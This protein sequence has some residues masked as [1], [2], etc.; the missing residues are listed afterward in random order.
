MGQIDIERSIR[1]RKL[2]FND[3]LTDY[4]SSWIDRAFIFL[5][6]ISTIYFSLKDLWHGFV[7]DNLP[8]VRIIVSLLFVSLASWIIYA[9]F[10]VD[11][12]TVI[13]GKEK[14]RN[15]ELMNAILAKM[16]S[17]MQFFNINDDLMIGIRPGRRRNS[18]EEIKVIYKDSEIYVNI[19]RKGRFGNSLFYVLANQADIKKIKKLFL[20]KIKMNPQTGAYSVAG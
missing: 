1:T 15:K 19:T 4:L 9:V 5:F 11:N 6:A 13:R 2:K 18:G 20:E 17:D 8:I 16:F 3:S 10:E 12:L 14:A 7:A